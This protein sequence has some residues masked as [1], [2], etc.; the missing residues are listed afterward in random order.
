MHRGKLYVFEGSDGAGKTTLSK[1]FAEHL[2]RIG[3]DCEWHSFP[4]RQPGS[5]GAHVY[6]L[7]H[8]PQIAG[9]ESISPTSLQLLHVAAHIDAIQRWFLPALQSGKTIVLD[10]FW[11]STLVYG[12][13]AGAEE[14][15]LLQMIKL[16]HSHWGG[17]IPT[18]AFLIRRHAARVEQNENRRKLDKYYR[19][20]IEREVRHHPISIIE[21]NGSLDESIEYIFRVTK[22]ETRVPNKLPINDPHVIADGDKKDRKT[23]EI[24]LKLDPAKPTVV[25]DT[26]WRFAAERQAVF[27]K[28]LHGQ[29]PPWTSDPIIREYKF[30]NAYRASD[31]VSQF[32]IRNVIYP[33]GQPFA[34]D[35]PDEIFF[36]ILIFKIFNRIDTWNLLRGEFGEVSFNNYSF[37]RYDKVLTK[38]IESE[39]RIYSAAYIMPTGGPSSSFRRKHHMHLRL[40]ERMVKEELPKR[41]TE[42][43]SMAE[44]FEML[45]AFPTIGD[46]LAYQYV[47]DLNYSTLT[48]FDEDTFVIPGPGARDGIR[49]CFAS[50][51]G[52]TEADL[53]RTVAARQKLEFERLE[54]SF[55]D[56]WG[57]P[58]QWIDCQNLFCEVDKYSRV[59]H[60]EIAGRTGRT[61]IK[62]KY[63]VTSE[64]IRYWYPPKWNINHR[65]KNVSNIQGSNG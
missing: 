12:L 1:L 28:R 43:K 26:Y 21:N 22:P 64:P 61:R 17:I 13:A 2:S 5:L 39:R 52:L 38:A 59:K 16:E 51:G 25:Y 20:L 44:A 45:R 4:G 3:H 27:F 57:R 10:R 49:K 48:Q 8:K 31:R 23:P 65:I 63:Q 18:R 40:V 35:D 6:E 34:K 30:T 55:Q 53:I 19:K 29:P 36:R 47:T 11:W 42:A 24:F 32:L 56:L 9:L 62:Q 33:G 14:R 7:H 41:I 58:L 37:S 54:L 15:S 60:P 46:F 50:L